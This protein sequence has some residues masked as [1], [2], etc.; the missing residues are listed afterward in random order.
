MPF[1][2]MSSWCDMWQQTCASLNFLDAPRQ[3]GVPEA[4]L[5]QLPLY[6]GQL[7]AETSDTPSADAL[8]QRNHCAVPQVAFLIRLHRLICWARSVII[9]I[10]QHRDVGTQC[11]AVELRVGLHGPWPRLELQSCA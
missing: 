3:L 4:H 7:E 11:R 5:Q 6:S 8:C 2:N 10:K 1:P 9:S